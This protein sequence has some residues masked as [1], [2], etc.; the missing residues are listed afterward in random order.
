MHRRARGVGWKLPALP[1]CVLLR[2][3]S[4]WE[5][6][7]LAA[8]WFRSGF[9]AARVSCCGLDGFFLCRCPSVSSCGEKG[10]DLGT[11][12]T[13]LTV[14]H[15]RLISCR[16]THKKPDPSTHTPATIPTFTPSSEAAMRKF[17]SYSKHTQCT[18]CACNLQTRFTPH[19]TPQS[20][21]NPCGSQGLVGAQAQRSQ[22]ATPQRTTGAVCCAG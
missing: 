3:V 11:K 17:Q 18:T 13:N 12:S 15:W 22:T 7:V 19:R 21:S 20:L 10:W 6:Q 5:E 2:Y 8:S 4:I 14:R 9:A 1:A 16:R